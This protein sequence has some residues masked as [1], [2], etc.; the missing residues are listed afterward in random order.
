MSLRYFHSGS[1]V[2]N[3]PPMQ[4]TREI[5]IQPLDWDDLLEK[6]TIYSNILAWKIPWAGKPGGLQFK[7]S[8]ID[9]TEGL[10]IAQ[11]QI[12]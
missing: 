5:R 2:K 7:G 12:M 9:A 8:P 3:S 4:E 6:M 10:S 1:V 11:N